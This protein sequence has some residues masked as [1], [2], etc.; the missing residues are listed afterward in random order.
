MFD[1]TKLS[2]NVNMTGKEYI[3][4]R[5]SRSLFNKP[6]SNKTKRALP[7]F[8]FAFCG[9]IVISFL[10]QHLTYTPPEPTSWQKIAPYANKMSWNNIGKLVVVNYAPLL[11][12]SIGI[13]WVLH[14]FGFLII[15][16]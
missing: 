3:E 1:D 8:I 15:K 16:G 12:I 6:L 2:V 4:Y 9:V 14:G 10:I 11:V 5:K 13:A 7:F